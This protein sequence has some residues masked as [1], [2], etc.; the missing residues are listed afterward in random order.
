MGRLCELNTL[1]FKYHAISPITQCG[2]SNFDV[3]AMRGERGAAVF[4]CNIRSCEPSLWHSWK[5]REKT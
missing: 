4:C 2:D 5:C 1:A 3:M